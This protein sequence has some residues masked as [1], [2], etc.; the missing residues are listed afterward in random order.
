MKFF[1]RQE[2]KTKV[3]YKKQVQAL[4]RPFVIIF[5][6]SFVVMNWNSIFW[7]FNYRV[8]SAQIDEVMPERYES[9]VDELLSAVWHGRNI[10]PKY[11]EQEDSIVISRIGITAPMVFVPENKRQNI[12]IS[13]LKKYLDRGVL[14]YPG[15]P[16]PGERGQVVILGHSAPLGWPLIK[17]DWVF[18]KLDKLKKG[19]KIVIYYNNREYTYRVRRTLFLKKGEELPSSTLT[20]SKFML[21]LV[22]C[23]P[24]GKDSERIVVEAIMSK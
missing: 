24:P 20:N 5:C 9:T 16:L 21:M 18:S 14:H 4:W 11:V 23:W 19:D 15:T 8:I 3:S 22:S 12:H 2:N 1:K 6:V 7:I 10:K 17:Y 13:A